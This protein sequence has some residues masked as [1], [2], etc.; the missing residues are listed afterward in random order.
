G[1]T[2]VLHTITSWAHKLT[3]VTGAVI[4][5]FSRVVS[6]LKGLFKRRVSNSYSSSGLVAA[7]AVVSVA[8]SALAKP[9]LAPIVASA[10]HDVVKSILTPF[11]WKPVVWYTAHSMAYLVAYQWWWLTY[12]ALWFVVLTTMALVLWVKVTLSF[13]FPF[14]FL[15]FHSRSCGKVP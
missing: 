5:L 15:T 8:T 14:L 4:S 12:L 2:S 13:L 11:L 9:I 3:Q 10:T 7:S 6:T 1:K